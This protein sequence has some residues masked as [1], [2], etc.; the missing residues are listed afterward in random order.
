MP[1]GEFVVV[2]DFGSRYAESVARRVREGGV[3]SEVWPNTTT[4]EAFAAKPPAAL[5]ILTAEDD[6]LA[7]RGRTFETEIAPLGLPTLVL[8]AAA[9]GG[10][11]EDKVDAFLT[12]ECQLEASWS[13]ERF[14]E[15]QVDAIR[16]TVGE[17]GKV[18]CGLSGGVDS[19]V[20]AALVHRALG[21]RLVSIFVDHGLL[22]K[23][24]PEQVRE[25]FGVRF[26]A[27]FVYVDASERFL[28][29]LTGVTDPEK[30]RRI[31]GEEFIRVFEEE[32]RKIGD[33]RFL[34]QGTVYPDVIESGVG[35]NLVKSHHN[36]GGLPEEMEL[37]LIEPLRYLFKDEVRK[38]GLALGLPEGLVWRQPF[39]GPGL[40]VRIVGEITKERVETERAC[41]A[42]VL[43]ELERAGLMREVWQAFAVLTE[44]RSVG[45]KADTR[46]Y[47][48]VAAVRAVVSRDA[49]T[50]EWARIPHEVL[51][52]IA[53]RI[54]SEVPAVGRVVYDISSKPPATIEWE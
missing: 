24:E 11:Y 29:K 42:I 19:S 12:K 48:A 18:V 20:A 49:M 25:I 39:P 40:A 2:V 35:G 54:L 34:V 22:R 7:K 37:E 32:A 46:T 23:G 53:Q 44:S 3:Y 41:D 14:I 5:I 30:K 1:N 21:D 27:N 47:G 4:I 28:G 10:S 43:E 13:I 9:L 31:I 52:R 51:D 26:G 33:V 36:V 6:G 17:Q 45:V 38:V 15:E 8:D 50:A 16:R